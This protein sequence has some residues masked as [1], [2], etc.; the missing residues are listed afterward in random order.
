MQR[1][2]TS[3]SRQDGTTEPSRPGHVL[4]GEEFALASRSCRPVLAGGLR[5]FDHQPSPERQAKKLEVRRS[6]RERVVGCLADHAEELVGA[7]FEYGVRVG[8]RSVTLD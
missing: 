5:S 6:S 7:L 1:R 4:N 8:Q 3:C 2:K